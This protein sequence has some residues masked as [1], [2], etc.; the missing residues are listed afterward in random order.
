MAKQLIDAKGR[1][2]LP[3]DEYKKRALIIKNNFGGKNWWPEVRKQLGVGYWEKDGKMTEFK[4]QSVGGGQIGKKPLDQA[5]AS[6]QQSGNKRQIALTKANQLIGSILAKTGKNK[7][8]GIQAF[9]AS[10]NADHIL[11]VQTFGPALEQLDLELESGAITQAEYKKRLA[12]IKSYN[13]GDHPDNLQNL[14]YA[15]N[16]EKMKIV[17][18]K[19]KAL[20]NMEI[21]NPSLRNRT[22]K[23]AALMSSVLKGKKRTNNLSGIKGYTS[24]FYPRNPSQIF[25]TSGKWSDPLLMAPVIRYLDKSIDVRL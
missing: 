3:Y 12:V 20:K 10:R 8:T 6:K 13:P 25:D 7:A 19:N 24:K 11:E 15:K 1:T 9:G 18:A 21:Q 22:P 16:Q 23:M 17:R 14:H 5:K 4:M 2:T